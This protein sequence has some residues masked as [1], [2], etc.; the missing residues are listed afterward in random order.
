MVRSRTITTRLPKDRPPYPTPAPPECPFATVSR[1]SLYHGAPPGSATKWMLDAKDGS[2]LNSSSKIWS[3]Y[4]K[5]VCCLL[6]A[7]PYMCRSR[8]TTSSSTSV[9]LSTYS[10]NEVQPCSKEYASSA[11]ASTPAP[12]PAVV[13]STPLAPAAAAAGASG[14]LPVGC[15][16]AVLLLLLPVPEALVLEECSA[17][18]VDARAD[19]S[20]MKRAPKSMRACGGGGA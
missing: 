4:M 1:C 19:A 12:T 11:A 17:C 20:P 3:M 9:R 15:A 16:A 14:L 18:T 6:L 5:E 8:G 10:L 7:A 2:W 13:A